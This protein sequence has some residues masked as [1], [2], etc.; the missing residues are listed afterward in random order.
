M[1]EC[2]DG[3]GAPCIEGLRLSPDQR[4]SWLPLRARVL[5]LHSGG[6][7]WRLGL[8]GRPPGVSRVGCAPK[9]PVPATRVAP[10]LRSNGG[11]MRVTAFDARP[12]LVVV[13]ALC[14]TAC[15]EE[16]P[17]G[18]VLRTGFP[19]YPPGRCC[20]GETACNVGPSVAACFDLQTDSHSCGVCWVGCGPGTCIAG[21]CQCPPAPVKYCAPSFDPPDVSFAVDAC[22]DTSRDPKNCGDCGVLCA[23]GE[24][25]VSGVCS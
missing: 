10:T 24:S 25:C 3:I 21:A 17:C 15:K 23:A 13:L 14:A 7:R 2:A 12:L 4:P 19:E 20:S 1:G 5:L 8:M 16:E 18:G 22:V 9:W 6:N 11:D